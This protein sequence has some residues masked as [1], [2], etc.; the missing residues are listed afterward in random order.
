MPVSRRSRAS[1]TIVLAALAIVGFNALDGFF[2]YL[3]GR[4]AAQASEGTVRRL[5]HE[6]YSHLEHLPCRYHDRADTG[7]LVQRCS[8]D[9]ETVRVFLAAQVVEIA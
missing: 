5:R 2:T 4:W 7:D 8:S 9:V 6:L 3:R 1:P